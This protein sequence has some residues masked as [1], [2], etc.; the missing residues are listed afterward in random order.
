MRIQYLLCASLILCGCAKVS[1]LTGQKTK[2]EEKAPVTTEKT[3]KVVTIDCKNDSSQQVTFEAKGDKIQKMV[4]KF[5]M[6]FSDLGITEDMNSDQIQSKIN[7]S[8]DEK[9]NSIEGV[10]VS[11]SLEEKQVDITVEMD[12]KK[13]DIN[14]L[15]EK[16]L[17]D[18]GE[19]QSNYV[20][21]KKTQSAY[22]SNGYAC[23]TK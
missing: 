1:D 16:G 23:M 12:F 13:A 6:S 18:K 5:T 22:K 20:S 15:I 4:Q 7:S 8:L 3:N 9:Y 10:H 17:L 21:L 11:T 14:T 19:A 2:S